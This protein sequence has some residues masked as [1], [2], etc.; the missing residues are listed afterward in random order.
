MPKNEDLRVTSAAI[1]EFKVTTADIHERQSARARV[2]REAGD[3]VL[4]DRAAA[5]GPPE[6]SFAKIASLWNGYLQARME[7]FDNLTPL[8]ACNMMELLKIARSISNPTHFDNYT[9]R[10]G[11]AACAADLAQIEMGT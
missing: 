9:D 1:N 5:Y 11:Y 7:P 10:A 4:V 3:A 2:L 8:D 6:D